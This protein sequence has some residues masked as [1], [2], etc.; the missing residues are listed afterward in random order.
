MLVLGGHRGGLPA[1]EW[2]SLLRFSL[3]L[4]RST[5]LWCIFSASFSYRSF[6]S[7]FAR[8][9]RSAVMRRCRKQSQFRSLVRA[10]LRFC[11]PD[12]RPPSLASSPSPSPSPAKP[13]RAASVACRRM[14]GRTWGG[15]PLPGDASSCLSV[16]QWR[17]SKR[18]ERI[19][20]FLRIP[21]SWEAG[22]SVFVGDMTNVMGAEV[23]AVVESQ[24]AK[25]PRRKFTP[26]I[27]I[28]ADFFL[29]EGWA[30]KVVSGCYVMGVPR[31]L[32]RMHLGLKLP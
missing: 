2:S 23:P 31:G 19:I 13:G 11:V 4:S 20:P 8:F 16:G 5:R 3:R 17:F 28:S 12:A 1:Y 32:W 18:A 22:C 25:A 24:I 6:S 29:A 27:K 7:F 10:V 15:R 14:S 30:V 9:S 26:I 21:S